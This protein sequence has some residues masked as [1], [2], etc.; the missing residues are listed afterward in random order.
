LLKNNSGLTYIITTPNQTSKA[1]QEIANI[2][3]LEI[4]TCYLALTG[5]GKLRVKAGQ[6]SEATK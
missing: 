5:A 6:L 4:K 3:S 1:H 2:S